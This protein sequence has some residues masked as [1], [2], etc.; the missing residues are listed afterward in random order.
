MR[1]TTCEALQELCSYL[2]LGLKMLVIVGDCRNQLQSSLS[3]VIY[4]FKWGKKLHHTKLILQNQVKCES[5]QKKIVK[6]D[7]LKENK[8][9]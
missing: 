3:I 4:H 1:E 9:N 8:N 7:N 5:K 6:I 2:Y